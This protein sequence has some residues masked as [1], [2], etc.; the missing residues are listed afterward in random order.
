MK[1]YQPDQIRNVGLCSHGGAGKTSLTEA[2]LYSSNSIDRLGN[3]E[4]GTT[5]TDFDK[6]EVDRGITINTS[7]A[8]CEW[9][10]HKLNLVDTP[11]YFDFIGD[12]KSSL[13]I[14]DGALIVVC[15]ASGVQVG[16]EQV[17]HYADE[18]D[19]PRV[20]FIN[21]MERENASFNRT[22]EQLRE[23]FG[24][25]VVPVMIPIGSEDS[26]EGVINLV[27]MKANY[28]KG[29][30]KEFSEEEIPSEY[31]E[32]ADNFRE[33]LMEAV[34][35]C[36]D[37]MLEK[38][39]E[40]ESLTED[41]VINGVKQFTKEG[42]LIPVLCGSAIQNIGVTQLMDCLKYYIPSPVDLNYQGFNPETEEEV[43]INPSEE[44]PFSAF[45]FKT[46]A[47]PYVGR[48]N[49]F[50]VYSGQLS[51]D[52]EA[53]NSNNKTSER[54]G[55]LYYLKGKEQIP[56]NTVSVGDIAAVSKLQK[57]A[58]GDTLSDSEKPVKL[59]EVEFPDPVISFAVVTQDKGDEEKV[60]TSLSKFLEE[61]P[62]L[63]LEKNDETKETLISGMGELQ[64]EIIIEKMKKKYGVDVELKTPKV[65]YKETITK[66]VNA[67]EKY[68]K[69][70][71]GRG[72]YG[73]V[74][75]EFSPLQEG[76][77]F[78]FENN[79]VGGVIPKTY[80]PAVEK[81]IFEAMETGVLAG[82]PVIDIK[83][84]LYDGSHHSV[85]SSEMA[86]K[87]AGAN[88]FKKGMQNAQPVLLEP[89]MEVEVRVPEKFMGDIMGDINSKR[90]K[91]QGMDPDG[92]YQIIKAYVPQAEMLRYAIDLRSM[93]QGR[94]TFT[95]VFSHYERVPDDVR[96]EIIEETT[97]EKEA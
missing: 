49:Y 84:N 59:P 7:V 60:G 46:V 65:P 82:Y 14:V 80:I 62:I 48:L 6:E 17:W 36:D 27:T 4:D 33:M 97:A 30:G 85:D 83:A 31:Q 34:A 41:E 23:N 68:K 78:Q 58:T 37:E 95:S 72:Q 5:T 22:L 81:G 12:V 20:V 24:D 35:E 53:Y 70:S 19:L 91:I 67:E 29:D 8:P 42:E 52:K 45:V 76:E 40:G 57:T 87:V 25:Q 61:D 75:I 11:G 38:Y 51:D 10:G 89:V 21:K 28:H 2:L 94:G 16:T 32:E 73:H 1:S 56:V 9:K 74:F 69:Q 15:A 90:G 63:N 64:L 93:A 55:K 3:V 77:G 86:F 79:I 43:K 66:T 50:R 13:R 44:G 26:F 47:D 39:L 88:A 18:N 92:D 71:G 54:I 96:D